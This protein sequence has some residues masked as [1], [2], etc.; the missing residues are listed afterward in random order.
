MDVADLAG[1][2]PVEQVLA[3]GLDTFE[4]GPVDAIGIGGEAALRARHANGASGEQLAVIAGDAVD[5]V[6]FGH[7]GQLC[8]MSAASATRS[9]WN[10]DTGLRAAALL[11]RHESGRR[12]VGVV[13]HGVLSPSLTGLMDRVSFERSRKWGWFGWSRGQVAGRGTDASR[14]RRC[15]WRPCC[16]RRS[17]RSERVRALRKRS[18]RLVSRSVR[19]RTARS[20]RWLPA[21]T[22]SCSLSSTGQVACWGDNYLRS[23]GIADQQRDRHA[24]NPVPLVVGLPPG[25]TAVSVT[26]GLWS[27]VCGVEHRAGGLL[28]LATPHGQL[29]SS[30][31]SETFTANPVPLVVGLPA[32]T[33]AVAVTV[34]GSHSCAVLNTGQVACWG[35]NYSGQLGSS[36]NSETFTPNPVPLMVGLPVDRTAVAVTAGRDH[37][38]AVLNTGEVGCW[39]QNVA[40]QLGSSTNSGIVAANPVPTLVGCRE[41]RWCR[42]PPANVIRVRC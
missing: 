9:R 5:R 35:S 8:L 30:T 13:G 31:N 22:H 10:D 20:H 33:T 38:C 19:P 41:G 36:T 7:E 16:C 14:C 4:H 18:I 29:G 37:T 27:F 42:S 1:R 23:V 40:G 32:G 39:G 15:W 6:A 21:T 11:H 2:P 24:A 25:T 3:V 28:G 17:S 12:E 34:G 26:A